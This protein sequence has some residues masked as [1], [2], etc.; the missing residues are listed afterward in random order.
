MNRSLS[1]RFVNRGSVSVVGPP[2]MTLVAPVTGST[3]TMSPSMLVAMTPL[4]A[5]PNGAGSRRDCE[6]AKSATAAAA[7]TMSSA[8]ITIDRQ[9]TW[10]TGAVRAMTPMGIHL[11]RALQ[12]GRCRVRADW[13][14]MSSR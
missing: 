1:P 5:G 6:P 2:M 3:V 13:R 11:S 7:R 14:S 4:R 10:R 12:R 9:G 8:A